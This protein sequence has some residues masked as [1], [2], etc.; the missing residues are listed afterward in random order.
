MIIHPL[1]GDDRFQRRCREAKVNCL[2]QI[3]I[4][5]KTVRSTA[6]SHPQFQQAVMAALEAV[7]NDREGARMA[8]DT[9]CREVRFQASSWQRR[10][11]LADKDAQCMVDTLD[12]LLTYHRLC[13]I[14][15]SLPHAGSYF[16]TIRLLTHQ[17]FWIYGDMA[18]DLAKVQVEWFRKMLPSAT[19]CVGLASGWHN[20][21]GARERSLS[22]KRSSFSVSPI[23]S[24]SF[25]E[26]RR[27]AAGTGL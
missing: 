26:R 19:R 12:G 5:E 7:R 3:F 2:R 4:M 11:E 20:T 15:T 8:V 22:Q 10:L 1:Q 14:T 21:H 16:A 17:Y 23:A 25:Q 6:S 9:A 13:D 18:Q 27:V 24:T